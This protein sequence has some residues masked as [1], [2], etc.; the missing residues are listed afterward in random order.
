[1]EGSVKH[2]NLPFFC[3]YVLLA[4]R[5]NLNALNI[6]ECRSNNQ[7]KKL[8]DFDVDH[9]E[10]KTLWFFL[11]R[12]HG[13]R[14]IRTFLTTLLVALNSFAFGQGTQID[15]TGFYDAMGSDKLELVINQQQLIESSVII[16]REAFEGALMMKK[17]ALVGN[18][19]QKLSLFRSGHKLLDAAIKRDSSNAEFRFL[20]LMIQEHAPGMLKYKG[21]I[22]NDS[23]LVKKGFNQLHPSTRKAIIEYSKKS[24]ILKPGDF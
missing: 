6:S 23:S 22:E 16:N 10:H 1:M 19:S 4:T 12:K 3:V 8:F 24:K 9:N 13:M 11:H 15:R 2:L 21:D 20:R 18:P 5:V 17:A 14:M 7:C